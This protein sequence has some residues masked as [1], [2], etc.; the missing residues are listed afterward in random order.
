MHVTRLQQTFSPSLG[1]GTQTLHL[2][3]S[4]VSP[5]G[6][7]GSFG[8]SSANFLRSQGFLFPYLRGEPEYCPF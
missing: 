2:H 5:A 4:G 8:S 1:I 7:S 3:H 6:G